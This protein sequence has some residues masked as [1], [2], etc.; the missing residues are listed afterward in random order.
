M[1]KHGQLPLEHRDADSAEHEAGEDLVKWSGGRVGDERGPLPAGKTCPGT[2]TGVGTA[3]V[4]YDC[5]V[6]PESDH[7][8]RRGSRQALAYVGLNEER[9]QKV[10]R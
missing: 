9:G 3:H 2:P 6:E 8:G 5:G 7:Q 10:E 4:Q 1:S